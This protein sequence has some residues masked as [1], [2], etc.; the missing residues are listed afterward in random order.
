MSTPHARVLVA[1]GEEGVRLGLFRALLDREVFC[2]CVGSAGEAIARLGEQAYA[3]VVLDYSLPRA[4]AA[5]VLEALRAIRDADR[6]MVIATALSA[7]GCDDESGLVQMILRRPLRIRH[8]AELIAACLHQ[9]RTM[10][11]AARSAATA[12]SIDRSGTS[13]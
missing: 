7:A 3:L 6:P 4:G 12:R 1:D 8:A 13:T 9:V 5:A 11:P 2:D 10:W